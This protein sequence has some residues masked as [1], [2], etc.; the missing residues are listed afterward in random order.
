MI[1]VSRQAYRAAWV[2]V[3][4]VLGL[5]WAIYGLV[6]NPSERFLIFMTVITVVLLSNTA[7]LLR[8]RDEK[9]R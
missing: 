3:A 6:H 8:Q 9:P 4:A 2:F 5:S 1:R 7:G